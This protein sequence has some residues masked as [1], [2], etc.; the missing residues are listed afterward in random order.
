MTAK[1]ELVTLALVFNTPMT[2]VKF[3]GKT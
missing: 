3:N 2:S 1:S